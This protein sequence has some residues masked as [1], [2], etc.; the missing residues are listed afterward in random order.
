MSDARARWVVEHASFVW[1]V[2]V[3][4]GVPPSRLEDASQEVFL[5]ALA[6]RFE[7]RSSWQSFLYGVCRN[8]AREQRRRY[9]D[10]SEI[11]TDE[12]PETVVQPAQEGEL[13]VKRAHERLLQ[14]LDELDETQREV[15]VLFE[16]T[17]LSMEEVAAATGAPLRTCYSRLQAARE[18]VQQE[19]RRRAQAAPV[20]RRGSQS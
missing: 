8:V 14:A 10:A 19:L 7:G 12:L 13:W 6:K 5:V 20:A 11:P 16:I 18:R 2:L 15:F 1:R 3:H 17:E 4:L 9:R